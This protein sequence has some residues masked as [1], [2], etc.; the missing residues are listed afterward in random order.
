MLKKR[1]S[2]TG[3][4]YLRQGTKESKLIF[5]MNR[6]FYL[7][8]ISILM[9]ILSWALF[10]TASA[11]YTL[12]SQDVSI[13]IDLQ[14][15]A[16][17]N[18][19]ADARG[20]TILQLSGLQQGGRP[21]DPM[22]PYSLTRVLLPADAD[23]TSVKAVLVGPSWQ[24]FPGEYDIASVP[25]AA[26]WD[27]TTP[28]IVWGGKDPSVIVSGRDV[29]IYTNDSF[30]P[31]QPFEI[32]SVGQYR[33]WKLVEIKVWHSAYNPLQKKVR[34]LSRGKINITSLLDK[35]ANLQND[36]SLPVVINGGNALS[37][38]IL[39]SLANPEDEA[40]FYAHGAEVLQTAPLSTADY[41]IITTSTIQT[42]STYLSSF[43]ACRE[44]CGNVVKVVTEGTSADD[45]HYVSGT[46]A[47]QRAN[48]IRSW[49]QSHYLTDGIDYVLL[50]GN[51][52]PSTF[53]STQSI[54][55]KM[56]WPGGASSYD[57]PSDMFYAELSGDWNLDSDGYYGEFDGD[58][59]TG[60]ADKYC[61]V[62]VGRIPFYGSYTD[63]DSILQKTISYCGE[64]G[65]RAWREKVLIPAAVSNFGPQD[66]NGD[67]DADDYDVDF[68]DSS[69]RTF[70]ADWGEYIKSYAN[71]Q[72][73][74]PYTLYERTGVY[75]D[76]SAYPTTSCNASLSSSNIISEWQNAYG[77][78]TW[79]G[80]G[81]Q[82]EA[83]RFCWT[84]DSSYVG[85]CGNYGSHLETTWYTMFNSSYCSQLDNDHPSFVAQI[86]CLNAYPENS[87]N[88]AYSLL[89][90]GA[91][92]TFAGTRVTWYAVGSW[93]TSYG[94]VYGDNAS[95]AYYIFQ[96]MA[97]SEDTAAEALDYCRNYFGTGW[98]EYSWMNMMDFNLYG[99]PALS[100][101]TFSGETPPVAQNDSVDITV[102]TPTAVT[103]LAMDD[104]LPDP[105]AILSYIITSLPDHGDLT[106][107]YNG[108]I[109]SVPYTLLNN[110]NQVI[111]TPDPGYLG[112]DSFNFKANDGG[113]PPE[114]GDSN[115]ATVSITIDNCQ[116]ITI[117]TGTGTWS[118][119]MYTYYHDSRTQVIYLAEEIG[120]PCSITALALY[121][122]TLPGQT[123]NYWTIR[124][125]HTSLDSY[126][127][128]SFESTGWTPI[129]V[130]QA[131]ETISGTGWQTFV[132]SEPFEYN[133][134]DNLMIDFSHNNTSWSSSGSCRYSNPGGTRSI[135]AYTDSGYGDPLDWEGSTSPTVN[136]SANVPNIQLTLCPL[137]AI[138]QSP[139]D[140]NATNK[141]PNSITWS[142]TDNSDDEDGFHGLDEYETEKWSV[143]ADVTQY[144]ESPLAAN[145]PY[146]RQVTADNSY[147]RSDP[148]DCAATVW[149]LPA[150]PNASCNRNTGTPPW[151]L[152]TIF[153]FNNEAGFGPD[154]VEY[155]HYGW[156]QQPTYSCTTADP[157]WTSAQ[158]NLTPNATGTWY[159]HLLSCNGADESGGNISY[160]P[161]LV[162]SGLIL[163]DDSATA[164]AD[165]GTS[166]PDAF[167]NL[168]SALAVAVS[169]DEIR[170]AQGT[171]HP[172]YKSDPCDPRS[173][174]FYLING[175][176]LK[177]GYA[178]L[179]APDPNARDPQAYLTILSG[180]LL[181]NDDPC[182]PVADLL[183]D[184]CRADNAYHVFYHFAIGLDSTALLDGFTI[185]AGNADGWVY[186]GNFDG[187]GMW[188]YH[189]C[190]P[191]VMNCTFT[192]NTAYYSGDGSGGGMYNEISNPI[193]INCKFIGNAAGN[194][195]GMVNNS[196][197]NSTVSNCTFIANLAYYG[198]G[199]WNHM[200]S[201][202]TV[203]NC[204]FN[205][206]VA[207]S[208][209]GMSNLLNEDIPVTNCI[210][211][212]NSANEGGGM[213]NTFNVN[214]IVTN[215]IFS[216]N[217][218]DT[219]GGGMRNS[220][221]NTTTVT[222]TILWGNTA[223]TAPQI[224]N[225][226]SESATVTYSN[227][228][229][230]FPGL[231][232]IDNDPCFVDPANDDYHLKSQGWRWDTSRQRWHYDIVTSRCIDAGNPSCPLADEPLSVP[233]DSYNFWGINLRINMGAY[234]GTSEASIP[235]YDWTLLS[236]L[237]NDGFTDLSDFSIQTTAWLQSDTLPPADFNHDGT[238]DV[239]DLA[240]LLSDWLSTTSWFD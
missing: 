4:V 63:L 121:V 108:A 55:M 152:G 73:F 134:T 95:Y 45:T 125:K 120:M 89:L 177:G 51:P 232:N 22:L 157:N 179:G 178:G 77:Y 222:N 24:E 199:M 227:V 69:D 174:A 129:Y 185:T 42:N 133:G 216:D 23:L 50:I 136:G 172:A 12:N 141:T 117:G 119:P 81:S 175:V 19:D 122:E 128:Y 41:V 2:H 38:Q 206:N 207:N 148:N 105:P 164:G 34:V 238:V 130:Y 165:N 65:S 62:H 1:S 135:Y 166:W 131:N 221:A 46:T 190:N 109:S 211:S 183:T 28:V 86:S 137:P 43:I 8:I 209:G 13:E 203:T 3:K 208:G 52:H 215:C 48:N 118:Y 226:E 110:G 237:T 14:P 31:K 229:G 154:G 96:R 235:P 59:G 143:A 101:V 188:N 138:P 33:Q 213:S 47:D 239:T 195:G 151:P 153:T 223:P 11:E 7:R 40:V 9:L 189:H 202:P 156:N 212:G 146:T 182:T 83:A 26:T 36:T 93:S 66:N 76:G 111:Y 155:Y 147:G 64:T 6:Q 228:Q 25:P 126:S 29:S 198:G 75:S 72:S 35:D 180:D 49:L 21:G 168:S 187:G 132:F 58:Y 30:F 194:G 197:S 115:T 233:D 116:T 39:S 214:I 74:T 17:I 98:D 27:G 112:P 68:P 234:G 139:S 224:Y 231:G 176:D 192:R 145:T 97:G 56:C 60:G 142:W 91:V 219:Y 16:E 170:V 204:T 85:I 5:E 18:L 201:N 236:D 57:T 82:T 106:D 61:E 169:G 196:E 171:Y 10:S 67:G 225:V 94:S 79:W 217:S 78:V 71:S 240:L 162:S 210:F 173:A 102:D 32:V 184:P 107:P 200:L 149:T 191:T 104:G 193:V 163:V 186:Y 144:E 103:L 140:L 158:L 150:D 220:N 161:F 53:S 218:A 54:P 113:S 127:T 205:C 167:I 80:H 100:H 160:G 90:D 15:G 20:D 70:G 99:D 181:D 87:G 114:G 123:M 37:Q 92:G 88:L 230:G 124:M 84:S 159:L 44:A